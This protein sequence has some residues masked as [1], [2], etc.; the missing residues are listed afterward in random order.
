MKKISFRMLAATAVLVLAAVACSKKDNTPDPGNKPDQPGNAGS[1]T[2][3]ATTEDA[4]T[5]TSLG[6]ADGAGKRQ[7]SWVANDE[8]AVLYSGGSTTANA[9]NVDG[10]KAQF[11]FDAPA[12]D[13]WFTYPSS[14]GSL[15]AGVLSLEI[16]AVQDGNFAA[17]SYLVAKA[18]T[19]DAKIVFFNACSMFK[20]VV[21]DAAI[22]QAVI[23]GNNNE[24][25]AGTVSYTWE[26]ANNQAPTADVT[27]ATGTSITVN[28]SGAGEYLV[29]ALPGLD[30]TAGATIKFFKEGETAGTYDVPAG[31]NRSS[32]ALSVARA[33]IASWGNSNA[34]CHR[35]VSTTASGT[36]NGRA[37]DKAWNTDQFVG[38]LAGKWNGADEDANK[39]AAMNGLTIHIAAGEYTLPDAAIKL[40]S[41]FTLLNI[42]GENGA[43]LKGNGSKP[44][45]HQNQDDR[46]GTVVNF[47]NLSFTGGVRTNDHGGAVWQS[48]GTFN[49]KDC[50]FS[51]NSVTGA[52]K[53]GGVLHFYNT[54]AATFEDCSF[55]DNSAAG[56]SANGGVLNVQNSNHLTFT[57][58]SF[59]NNTATQDGGVANLSGTGSVIRFEDCDFGDGTDAKRNSATNYGGVFHIEKANSL[60][61]VNCR[62]NNNTAKGGGA[63]N[64]P[65]TATVDANA[66]HV[67][68]CSFSNHVTSSS[69]AVIR[70][71][72]GTLNLEKDGTTPCTFTDNGAEDKSA[73]VAVLSG[74]TLNDNGSVYKKNKAIWGG[75]YVTDAD[76]ASVLNCT[77]CIYGTDGTAADRNYAVNGGGVYNQNGGSATF[78]KC[79]FYG[80]EAKERQGGA[81]RRA[82]DGDA[83]DVTCTVK[84]CTFKENICSNASTAGGS[85]WGSSGAIFY[86]KGKLTIAE[87]DDH[88]RTTFNGNN[89]VFRGGAIGLDLTA[90]ADIS[91]A[92]FIGNYTT[93]P[94]NGQLIGGAICIIGTSSAS[95]SDCTFVGNYNNTVGYGGGA[96]GIAGT[97]VN[98]KVNKSLFKDN[99]ATAGGAIFNY[100]NGGI[101]Y[102]NACAF[103][104][105]HITA[106]YGV[107]IQLTNTSSGN[108]TLC[109]NNC[110]FA[111][112][113]YA[114]DGA[115]GQQSCW[116]NLKGLTKAVL[117]NSTLIGKT[118]NAN[119]TSAAD[120][121]SPNLYR[122]D[123]NVGSGNYIINSIIATPSSTY[124]ASDIKGSPV[125]GY[126]NKLS[127]LLNGST[128]VSGDGCATD[129][130][131]TST[132][133]GGLGSAMTEGAAATDCYWSW[134][135]TLATGGDLTK[136]TLADV[137]STIQ[138]A[139]SGFYN[140]L[141]EIGA[142][143]TDCR[144]KNRST[145]ATWPGAYDGT[146]N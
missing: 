112:N 96:L 26:G 92:D 90:E 116:V 138:T 42:V 57:R 48:Y 3:T 73:G 134:N 20:I 124:Y 98:V 130:Y 77:S 11:S 139:D 84:G 18:L 54:A 104:G 44:I 70:I 47:D 56:T 64:F 62:F 53:Y 95:I 143:T 37:A 4:V 5:K 25:L 50:V 89:S 106:T 120:G 109:M 15:D 121:T 140:W 119:G 105:N 35:Y 6:A 91:G 12:G 45:I 114:K 110:S 80:N 19:S 85:S 9:A 28:F 49:F 16:P 21:D 79:E 55:T 87:S 41:T 43:I 78:T 107:V 33:Q 117:S 111:D 13:V 103:T 68:G 146:N 125:T 58:C 34:I 141:S 24:K 75:V 113:Q 60:N 17:H 136:A 14:A 10:G 102:L 1:I 145:D 27:A 69:G 97:T 7:V 65:G 133:F 127:G 32:A 40:G 108:A 128:Y 118:R 59:Y 129:F 81:I 38:F 123:G 66:V 94:N 131:G 144:G 63:L 29:A 74:G 61:I 101:I 31:G 115:T 142:L 126:Y 51:G 67:Q 52:S 93:G 100:S 71:V 72:A 99:Y 88:V 135:G 8:V 132:Y 46:G 82:T 2:M 137:N 83:T 76:K 122:F 22:K 36:D 39:L 23:T 86:Q 30:L